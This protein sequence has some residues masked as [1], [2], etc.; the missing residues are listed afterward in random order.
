[1]K[2]KHKQLAP[3][4]YLEIIILWNS[5]MFSSIMHPKRLDEAFKTYLDKHFS[6]KLT[7]TRI[8][9]L[10]CL[11]RFFKKHFQLMPKDMVG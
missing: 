8:D 5:A 11:E 4:A 1:M 6:D 2:D 7:F 10:K 3:S 9:A